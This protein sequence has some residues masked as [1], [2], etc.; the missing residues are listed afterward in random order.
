[1][2]AGALDAEGRRTAFGLDL[3]GYSGGGSALVRASRLA[4]DEVEATVY[5]GHAFSKKLGKNEPLG[6]VVEAETELLAACMRRA[7]LYVDVPIDL[8]GLPC[9]GGEVFAWQL[10]ERLVDQAF[11][12]LPPPSRTASVRWSPGSQ[13]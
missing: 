13:T 6:R 11:G 4:D 9:P 12:A 7:P 1:M 5:R 3:G 10:V 8:Q 2:S